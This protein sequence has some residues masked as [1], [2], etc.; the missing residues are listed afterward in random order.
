MESLMRGLA[1]E[2]QYLTRDY[3]T[4]QWAVFK[5]LV[6]V[7]VYEKAPDEAMEATLAVVDTARQLAARHELPIVEAI[8]EAIRTEYGA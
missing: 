8:K 2:V 4:D 1:R 3:N 6:P 7:L 5:A